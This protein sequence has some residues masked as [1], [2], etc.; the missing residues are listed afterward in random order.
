MWGVVREQFRWEEKLTKTVAS[1]EDSCWRI[2]PRNRWTQASRQSGSPHHRR[3]TSKLPALRRSQTVL[4]RTQHR[5]S[6]SEDRG[7]S[8]W[9]R[10]RL[11]RWG[12]PMRQQRKSGI[13]KRVNRKRTGWKEFGIR[14]LHCATVWTRLAP[15]SLD[16]AIFVPFRESRLFEETFKEASAVWSRMTKVQVLCLKQCF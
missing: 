10:R 16:A 14:W 9:G 13:G 6:C 5:R 7:R 15:S 3:R 4:G 2:S 12:R 1:F 8:R 11:S